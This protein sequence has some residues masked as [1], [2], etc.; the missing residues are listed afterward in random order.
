MNSSDEEKQLEL[1]ASLK[2]RGRG[3][4]RLRPALGGPALPPS[5]G[6][7]GLGWWERGRGEA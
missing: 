2:D 5:L 7:R 1:L 3:G 6:R 4:R